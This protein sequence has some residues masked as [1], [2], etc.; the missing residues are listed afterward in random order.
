MMAKHFGNA[1]WKDNEVD[2]WNSIKIDNTEWGVDRGSVW[3]WV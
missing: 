2:G 1:Y 3:K